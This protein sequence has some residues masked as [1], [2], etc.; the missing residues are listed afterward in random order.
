MQNNSN[1]RN[2]TI[3]LILA[4]CALIIPVV[5]IEMHVMQ[6]T[7]GVLIYPLDDT[8]IHMSIAKNLALYNNW[9]ISPNQFQSASSSILYTIILSG[10]FKIF[11]VNTLIP[12]I[13]NLIAGVVLI[14]VIQHKL[15]K[16]NTGFT[17]QFIILLLVIFF[18]P[19]PTLIISGMEH[20]L[21]CLFTFLFIFNFF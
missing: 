14:F 7:N 12:F 4:V 16:E 3:V 20:T 9:G 5:L 10:L 17:S 13:V 11:S 18:T 19:L 8:Y 6:F 15:Q 21:Q 2:K 1:I